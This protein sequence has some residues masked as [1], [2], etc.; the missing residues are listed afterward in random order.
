M[1]W[2]K[3]DITAYQRA[4]ERSSA[5]E[6]GMYLRVMLTYY[7]REGSLPADLR[8]IY[9]LTHASTR[10]EKAAVRTVL[11]HFMVSVNG[12][13]TNTRADEEIKEY[14]ARQD[15]GRKA[16]GIRWAYG[17]QSDTQYRNKQTNIQP[18][19]PPTSKPTLNRLCS[20][21]KPANFWQ[22]S[23]GYCKEHDPT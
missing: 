7:Q 11:A 2:F 18:P 5:I 21:G 14:Q 22:G 10:H 16:A 12:H 20:C 13:Y 8:T 4:T 17:A 6:D 3:F 23:T 15:A 19:L 1:D 9:R